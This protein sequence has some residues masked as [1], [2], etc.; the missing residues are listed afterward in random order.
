MISSRLVAFNTTTLISCHARSHLINP[1][2]FH[3]PLG[4]VPQ[5]AA[6]LLPRPTPWLVCTPFFSCPGTLAPLP[7]PRLP[8]RAS[9]TPGG[10]LPPPP[11]PRIGPPAGHATPP[12]CQHPNGPV[13]VPT[14]RPGPTRPALTGSDL[15]PSWTLS[16]LASSPA[17]RPGPRR[18]LPG[19]TPEPARSLSA[20]TPRPAGGGPLLAPRLTDLTASLR[21]HGSAFATR[22]SHGPFP[23]CTQAIPPHQAT[24]LSFRASRPSQPRFKSP[25]RFGPATTLRQAALGAPA[26]PDPTALPRRHGAA[27][28]PWRSNFA[29]ISTSPRSGRAPRAGL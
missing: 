17:C 24:L 3:A 1:S 15:V 4:R 13:T 28:A 26:V 25:L 27:F 2:I 9:R 23:S 19:P 22:C 14:H 18:Y 12:I 5:R 29:A 8:A 11:P 16:H 20:T 10:P 7:P 21:R 6:P